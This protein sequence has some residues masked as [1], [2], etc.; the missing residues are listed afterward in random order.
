MTRKPIGFDNKSLHLF[1]LAVSL[2]AVILTQPHQ[3]QASSSNDDDDD[4]S[5][6]G[7]GGQQENKGYLGNYADGH[8]AGLADGAADYRNGQKEFA[9]CP[10]GSLDYCTGYDVGYHDG[11]DS[12]SKVG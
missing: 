8:R 10:G 11:Y 12:A 9:R 6:S 7:S 1:V 2:L 3:V 5:D 4:T